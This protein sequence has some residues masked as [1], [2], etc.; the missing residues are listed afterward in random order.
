MICDLCDGQGAIVRPVV[1]EYRTV[2]YHELDESGERQQITKS[3]VDQSGG[4]DA[5]PTCA[6]LAHA[7]WIG[8]TTD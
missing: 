6:A 2:V 4:I 5:C 3:V 8:A 1:L 7:R